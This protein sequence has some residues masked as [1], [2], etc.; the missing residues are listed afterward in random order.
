MLKKFKNIL[1]VL[2]V[3]FVAA[4]IFA[5]N[6]KQTEEDGITIEMLQALEFKDG[7]FGYDG[8][9][10]SITIENIYEEQ[11]VVINYANNNKVNPGKYTVT[12]TITYEDLKVNKK[13][14]LRIEKAQS[15]LEAPLTQTFNASCEKVKLDYTVNND[16]QKILTILD[17]NGNSTSTDKIVKPGIYNIEIFVKENQFYKESNH[18][19]IAVNII[20]SQFDI[21]FESKKEIADGTEKKLEIE[22]TLPSGYTVEYE[23]NLGTE[24]GNYYATAIIKDSSDKVVETHRAVLIIDN[25][26]N[27]DFQEYLDEF[28][29]EYLE[30]DQ[31]SVNIFC[32]KPE[33]F[34]LEHYEAEWY[35]YESFGEEEIAHDLQVF[36]DYLT[37]LEAFKDA[38][39][40]DLQ[41]SA[42]ETIRKFLQYN[43][44]Y[45]SIEDSFFM[46]V[47]YVDQF[48]G[49]VADFGTYMEA[50]SLRTEAEV[51]DIVNYIESTKTAFPS[52]LSY[53]EDRADAGYP[54][55]DFT[56][57]EMRN[58]LKDIIDDNDESQYYLIDILNE[59]VDA[60]D[61]LTDEE[62][63]SYKERITDGIND[64]FMVGVSDL[65]NGLENHLGVLAQADEGY[66]AAY[67]NGKELYGLEIKQLLGY[68]DFDFDKYIKELDSEIN[69]S[70]KKVISTQLAL[71]SD[72]NLNSWGELDVVLKNNS[73][74]EGT[75]EEM[76]VYLKEF[77]K[78]VVPELKTD[79]DI[80]I[81]EMDEAS[82][83][84]SNAVA[85][86]MK[87]A[88]DNTSSENITLNPVQLQ[89]ATNNDV[90]GTLAHEGYPGH[91][92]AYVYSK[93]S[94]L[95]N[96]ATIMTSTAHAEGWATYIE[97][98]LY[99]Y[100]KNN[101]NSKKFQSVMN[102][103]YANQLT[104]FLLETRLDVGVH[105]E[106]W[107]VA[108]IAAYMEN[109]GYASGQAKEI[110]DLLIEMPSQ[111]A[112]YGYGKVIFNRLHTEAQ[113]ILGAYYD[114]VEFNGMLLSKGWT[115][116]EILEETYDNYMRIKCHECGI[117]YE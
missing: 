98:K 105:Y 46:E 47:M 24:D 67:E 58:Y 21:T 34:G 6:D 61:F 4:F 77:A 109:A 51:E 20:E 108:E 42:Y 111:Y 14:V 84:V 87:S 74:F 36:K 11:G 39:L 56:I 25:P 37:E 17:E 114:E 116:L 53:L 76:M 32:E 80:F 3:V 90:L 55:S 44:D 83:K 35:S 85:Y 100:A 106:G 89:S 62:K 103:L 94:G 63:A 8:E 73:I 92:Y 99:E 117:A 112:A 9:E 86:Y 22:G 64:Y 15:V 52:Y 19:K 27:E 93:E 40:N 5:C 7:T 91:L 102:Y 43:I 78:T 13:A 45:Y 79:P 65:Y 2:V 1:K 70:I 50:Y 16:T 54:L 75:P 23:N 31:L 104:G 26:E 33:D 88:L 57:T 12:A 41:E 59:K 66:L 28:F 115:D 48:G 82:A 60:V 69:K 18:V 10:H 110:Y 113:S 49:Y 29:V 81:K 71:F 97:L 68:S 38:K 72:F 95:S 96:L 101:S 30:G 107:G